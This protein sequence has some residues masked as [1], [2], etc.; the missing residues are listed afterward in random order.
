MAASSGAPRNHCECR[1]IVIGIAVPASCVYLNSL[2]RGNSACILFIT[3]WCLSP[4]D[5]PSFKPHS[6]SPY[7]LRAS[8]LYT[9]KG[10]FK[11]V[12]RRDDMRMMKIKSHGP[13]DPVM[14]GRGGMTEGGHADRNPCACVCLP[15]VQAVRPATEVE[16]EIKK[17]QKLVKHKIAAQVRVRCSRA[18]VH[19]CLHPSR[20]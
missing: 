14:S 12:I 9:R 3:F 15:G 8:P 2:E 13:D 11:I 18:C 19:V 20:R 16:E 17:K 7:H 4:S 6:C 5:F 10:D 1:L